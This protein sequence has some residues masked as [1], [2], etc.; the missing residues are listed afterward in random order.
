MPLLPS[1]AVALV[2]F[3][4]CLPAAAQTEEELAPAKAQE[5]NPESEVVE[6]L[7]LFD[8]DAELTDTGWS[9]LSV[10]LGAMSLEA[11]G[12]FSV[13]LPSGKT[14][15]VLDL[16]RVGLDKDDWS[17][18]LAI[19]W[20]SKQSRWGAWFATWSYDA[21]GY[22]VWEDELKIGDGW[23]R[24]TAPAGRAAYQGVVAWTPSA[25]GGERPPEAGQTAAGPEASDGDDEEEVTE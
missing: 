13:G 20:R 21:A 22:R 3:L 19:Y 18:W 10:S 8:S 12:V 23:L 5:P 25:T 2:S 14:V 11:D 6:S 15:N 7:E 17:H 24:A 16:D 1:I 4:L 9:Q